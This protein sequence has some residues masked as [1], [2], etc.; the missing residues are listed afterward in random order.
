MNAAPDSKMFPEILAI[1]EPMVEFNQTGEAGGRRYLQ[2]FGGDTSNFV[3]AT[4]PCLPVDATGAGDAF[5]GALVARLSLAMRRR[6]PRCL[7]GSSFYSGRIPIAW[8]SFPQRSLS[9]F[10]NC[11]KAALS[12]PD[13]A[14]EP[15]VT[16]R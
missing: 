13:S 6:S 10:I 12:M 5:A 2:G 9:A 1:G 4:F 14:I 3:I 11:T 8:T 16:R 7:P 15:R